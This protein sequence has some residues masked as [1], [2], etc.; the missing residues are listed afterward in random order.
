MGRVCS[1]AKKRM[2]EK[3]YE[4]PDG[5]K[6]VY[7]RSFGAPHTERTL[8]KPVEDLAVDDDWNGYDDGDL[9]RKDDLP[10]EFGFNLI[11][12]ITKNN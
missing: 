4:S 10:F 12:N 3:I 6:T 9:Q 5:G 11:G 1:D 2:N 7:Q 8:V